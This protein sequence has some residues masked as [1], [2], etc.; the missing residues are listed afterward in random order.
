MF[1]NRVNVH[2]SWLGNIFQIYR[3]PARP[4]GL[5]LTFVYILFSVVIAYVLLAAVGCQK[6]MLYNPSFGENL[7]SE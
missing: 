5:L 1:W 2:Q 4:E 7:Y 3:W 6:K